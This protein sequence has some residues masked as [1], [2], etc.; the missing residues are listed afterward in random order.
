MMLN[1][2]Y[3]SPDTNGSSYSNSANTISLLQP[4]PA[5]KLN[6]S[7][8]TIFIMS[9]LIIF[10]PV[11]SQ[12]CKLMRW[13]LLV[14]KAAKCKIVEPHSQVV[15]YWR[16]GLRGQA[17]TKPKDQYLTAWEWSSTINQHFATVTYDEWTLN[18]LVL[19]R[20]LSY[21]NWKLKSS[22][23]LFLSEKVSDITHA[24]RNSSMWHMVQCFT[25]Y[26]GGVKAYMALL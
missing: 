10:A 1:L 16:P 5:T 11:A 24:H 12:H 15:K 9:W 6:F 25:N 4:P 18:A 21:N 3:C 14:L 7:P 8:L 26:D 23:S 13:W 17:P 20:V 2:L 22:L 19:I